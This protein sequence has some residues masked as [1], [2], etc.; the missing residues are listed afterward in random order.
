MITYIYYMHRLQLFGTESI[1]LVK[2]PLIIII[3]FNFISV[4]VKIKIVIQM[5]ALLPS[6]NWFWKRVLGIN[7]ICTYDLALSIYVITILSFYQEIRTH[8]LVSANSIYT[9]VII[10]I[11]YSNVCN[12]VYQS[13]DII[14][15]RILLFLFL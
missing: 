6:N 13:L 2:S 14:E 9:K 1:A 7:I 5:D 12:S 15:N 8:Y 3:V 10:I 11:L 4:T